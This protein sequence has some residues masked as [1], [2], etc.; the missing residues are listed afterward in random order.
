MQ[1]MF[2]HKPLANHQTSSPWKLR[3][4]KYLKRIFLDSMN[5]LL[6]GHNDGILWTRLWAV[7]FHKIK[8][9]IN[10]ADNHHLYY[11]S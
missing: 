4:F 11:M 8:Q 5:C 9:F 10:Q 1:I 6:I 7:E 3:S 2:T